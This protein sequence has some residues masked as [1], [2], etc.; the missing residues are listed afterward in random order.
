MPTPA[1]ESEDT[2]E[3]AVSQAMAAYLAE[4]LA[5]W[6]NQTGATESDGGGVILTDLMVRQVR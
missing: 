1:D 6:S 5:F 4:N 3:L 2:A